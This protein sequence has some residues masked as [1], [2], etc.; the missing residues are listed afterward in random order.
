VPTICTFH[1]IAI[2]MRF[3][4]HPPP[5]FH[6]KYAEHQA[7]V[8]IHTLTVVDGS[9]PAR[10]LRLVREW[11]FAHRPELME[12]WHRARARVPLERIE[13]L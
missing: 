11:G 2:V 12:N 7:S 1:G 10:K 8:A 6:A 3:N 4:E 5:H 13:P 9:L